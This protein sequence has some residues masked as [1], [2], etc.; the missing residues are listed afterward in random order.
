MAIKETGTSINIKKHLKDY[1]EFISWSRFYPDLYLDLIRPKSGGLNLTMDQ[2]VLM[3]AIVRFNST[4][5]VFSRGY[6]KCVSGDALLFTNDGM[7]EIESF[8]KSPK[9]NIE[10]V[11][12]INISM[13]NKDGNIETSVLGNYDGFKPTK[14]IITRERFE[15][16]ATHVHPIM[17]MNSSGA[18]EWKKAE[19]LIVGDFI[20]INRKN[21]VWGN[22]TKLDFDLTEFSKIKRKYQDL[23]YPIELT[24]D[25]SYYMGLIIGDGCITRHDKVI[26]LQLMMKCYF[27]WRIFIKQ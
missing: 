22:K 2:R 12:P 20:C 17:I 19:D 5:G 7:R 21:D 26:L 25:F 11:E 13:A 23:N 6:G 27:L 1:M 14:K 10:T 8:F 3:R 9:T 16:E 15:L 4:Y 18:L 24:K